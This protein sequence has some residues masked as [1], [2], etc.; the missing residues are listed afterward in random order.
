[1]DRCESNNS[2][3]H[4][5]IP[6][7][8]PTYTPVTHVHTCRSHT[9]RPHTH[10]LP[11]H[12][13]RTHTPV[14]HTPVAHTHIALTPVSHT[15]VA[16]KY[17]HTYRSYTCHSCQTLSTGLCA[18]DKCHCCKAYRYGILS[19]QTAFQL[20]YRLRAA[21]IFI[22]LLTNIEWTTHTIIELIPCTQ[23]FICTGYCRNILVFFLNIQLNG[24]KTFT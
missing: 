21:C 18:G 8:S 15:P 23:L 7:L 19:V 11:T 12:T 2:P 10:L 3:T 22:I 13:Y 20:F 1:M 24:A 17:A 4:L 6:H 16:H 9:Y 5:S 14:A